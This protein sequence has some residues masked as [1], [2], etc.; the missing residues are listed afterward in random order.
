MTITGPNDIAADLYIMWKRYV[1]VPMRHKTKATPTVEATKAKPRAIP[2]QIALVRLG[3]E[4]DPLLDTDI[5]AE[6]LGV[7]AQWLILGRDQDYGPPYIQIGK[8]LTRY[9]KSDLDEYKQSL[10]VVP[11][12][13][14][15]A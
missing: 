4:S 2:A 13:A 9:S 6:Y 11:T 3:N 15:T 14:V 1:H 10:R 8:R 12:R 7:S 5:A